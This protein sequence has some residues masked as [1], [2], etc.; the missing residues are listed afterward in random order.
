MKDCKDEPNGK[1]KQTKDQTP[2]KQTN[3]VWAYRM[4]PR[5]HHS[6]SF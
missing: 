3:D 5:R 2:N 4:E 6:E 1:E